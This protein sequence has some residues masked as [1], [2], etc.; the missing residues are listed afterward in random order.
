MP[1]GST[2]SAPVTTTPVGTWFWTTR[3]VTVDSPVREPSSVVQVTAA[4]P[5]SGEDHVAVRPSG[6]SVPREALQVTV[7]SAVSASSGVHQSVVVWLRA[8]V[9][10]LATSARTRGGRLPPVPSS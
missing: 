2:D 4:S 3:S 8:S 7:G 10:S 9:V 6:T 5:V 1:P